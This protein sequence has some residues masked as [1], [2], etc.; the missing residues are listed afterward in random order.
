MNYWYAF[1][2]DISSTLWGAVV[3]IVGVDSN[4]TVSSSFLIIF[5]FNSRHYFRYL[6]NIQKFY[7]R[8]HGGSKHQSRGNLVT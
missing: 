3:A 5:F 6:K 2:A 8:L 7:A 1:F 4:P